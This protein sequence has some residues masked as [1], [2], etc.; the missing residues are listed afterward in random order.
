MNE[1][2][3]V[4]KHNGILLIHQ[5]VEILPFATVLMKLEGII[6]SEVSQRKI[7]AI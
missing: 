4:Y 6:F 2:S 5:E 3:V 7:K 1:E